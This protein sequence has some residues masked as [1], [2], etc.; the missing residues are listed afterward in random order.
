MNQSANNSLLSRL[1]DMFFVTQPGPQDGQVGTGTQDAANDPAA[2]SATERHVHPGATHGKM[3]DIR[4][5]YQEPPSFLKFVPFRDFDSEYGVFVFDDGLNCGVLFEIQPYP[6]EARSLD[7]LE[8][9]AETIATTLREAIPEEVGSPWIVQAYATNERSLYQATQHFEQYIAQLKPELLKTKFTQEWIKVMRAHLEQVGR[10]EGVFFD[11]SAKNIPWSGK[12][13][14]HF[15]ALYRRHSPA[16]FADAAIEANKVAESFTASLQQASVGVR[17]CTA[18]DLYEWMF[19]WLS[20][21]P[22]SSDG[23]P[24]RYVRETPIYDTG[25]QDMPEGRGEDFIAG[26]DLGDSM[27]L[28]HPVSDEKNQCWWFNGLPHRVL[29]LQQ[30]TRSP[31][32]G[33]LTAE[34]TFGDARMT[35]LDQMPEGTTFVQTIV[36]KPQHEVREELERLQVASRGHREESRAAKEEAQSCAVE[37][38]AGNKMYPMEFSVYV[39]GRDIEHLNKVSNEVAGT[40]R[41]QGLRMM[42]L[43]HDFFV[44]HKYVQQL[45]FAY[46]YDLDR[47]RTN[48]ARYVFS[49]QIARIMPIYGRGVGT[50]N[51]GLMFFNRGAEPLMLDPIKD[52]NKNAHALI[53][54]PSGSGKSAFINGATLNLLAVHRPRVFIIDP[55]ASFGP[56]TEYCAALGLSTSYLRVGSPGVTFNPYADA[57]ELL[58]EPVEEVE[59]QPATDEAMST[60]WDAWADNEEEL[61]RDLMGEMLQKTQAMVLA[62]EGPEKRAQGLKSSLKAKLR[63]VILDATHRVAAKNQERAAQ[64]LEP[65]QVTPSDVRAS[66]EERAN[67]ENS[68][69]LHDLG[70]SLANFCGKDTLAGRMFDSQGIP[71]P[72]CDVTVIE[73]GL[74]ANERYQAE[75]IVAVMSMFDR[76]HYLVEKNQHDDRMTLIVHDEV[77]VQLKQPQLA[78]YITGI[79][80]LWRKLG[81]WY[82]AATQDFQD[83]SNNAKALLNNLEWTFTL[84]MGESDVNDMGRFR[85]LTDDD[86]NL[87]L[88]PNKQPGDYVEGVV[89]RKG[90]PDIRMLFRSVLP[91]IALA[92]A[93]TE[94]EEKVQRQKLIEQYGLNSFLEANI[95]LAE[96]IAERRAKA[97]RMDGRRKSWQE[98]A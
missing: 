41:N 80:K 94:K 29:T 9:V 87:L 74:L 11:K 40:L 34:R 65:L 59:Q 53:L 17:R 5:A 91:P 20:P 75:M 68:E 36:I 97:T 93:G 70:Y 35:L 48:R 79:V 98:G 67:K 89:I 32:Y 23:D 33:H 92:L 25:H 47:R 83:I 6:T 39:R 49:R 72:E 86:R 8:T 37:I 78:P 63:E 46:R 30:L 64:G 52:R 54:G 60:T 45:P 90:V 38:E 50:G 16:S 42:E 7:E 66:L 61:R 4:R 44:L 76:I 27:V 95:K 22:P 71:M 1:T 73:F 62:N 24:Y 51:P 58:N 2:I 96:L 18:K 43:G 81:A 84:Q 19:P 56:I 15:I 85:T 10:P 13:A 55:S 82:W 21:C 77:H 28:G 88:S 14:R 69:E 3:S 57:L 31:S 12:Q 26:Y